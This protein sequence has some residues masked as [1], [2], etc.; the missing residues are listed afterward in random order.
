LQKKLQNI[1]NKLIPIGAILLVIG[2]WAFICAE[3]I[4]P[5]FMLPSP[6]DVV[7]AFIGDFTLLMKHASITLVEAFWGL[8]IGIIIGFV[9]SIL[10]DQFNFAYRGFYP[11]VVITQTIPTIAIAP[12]LVL[13][14]GYGMG[15]KVVL[16]V[17]TTFFPIT[18]GLLDGFKSV[19]FDMVDLMRAMG[20]NK[21]K[22]F[23]YIK[24]PSAMTN[25]F[26]GL[27]ISVTYSIVGAVI[28]EW[29]GGFNGLGV[30]MI[31]VKK[32]YAFDKMFAVILL[33][34]V[35]SLFLMKIVD[36]LKYTIMKW[37]RAK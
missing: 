27:R 23:R 10:M 36:L 14:M 35:L 1:T 7:R 4:V 30:Y 16:V 18:I 12:L 24:L 20:A 19:D 8:V 31:R 3:D 6:N 26:S 9:V 21:V 37:E 34:S 29:L 5:T 11:L 2:I 15:P 32:S 17:L 28:S 22:I 13:W 33:I 25:F